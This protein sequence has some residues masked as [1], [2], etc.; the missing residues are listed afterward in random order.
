MAR[1]IEAAILATHA[2]RLDIA[3]E[4]EGR[5]P[6]VAL[7]SELDV[8]AGCHIARKA[9]TAQQR[10]IDG[11]VTTDIPTVL[12]HRKRH[13]GIDIRRSVVNIAAILACYIRIS[14]GSRSWRRWW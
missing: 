5:G 6:L 3:P 8:L 1:R 12:L 11:E 7:Y 13:R 4:E 2:T 9:I 14:D 10:L